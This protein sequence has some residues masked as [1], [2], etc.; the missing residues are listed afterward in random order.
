MSRATG[1]TTDRELGCPFSDGNAIITGSK[2]AVIYIDIIGL[3]DMQAIR[4]GAI[5]RSNHTE[6]VD[7]NAFA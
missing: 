1:D 3:A 7:L 2:F 6:I 5:F 4:V